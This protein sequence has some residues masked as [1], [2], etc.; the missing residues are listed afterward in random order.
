MRRA[1]TAVHF[2]MRSESWFQ[3]SL[4]NKFKF[5]LKSINNIEYYAKR[6]MSTCL[7]P[8][9]NSPS[10]H[11]REKNISNKFSRHSD[12]SDGLVSIPGKGKIFFSS[13]QR[14]DR[15]WGPPSL[16]SN[17]YRSLFRRSRMTGAWSS[18]EVKNGGAIPLLP[19]YVVMTW[20]LI[21]HKDKFSVS[22]KSC[23]EKWNT[24]SM[25]NKVFPLILQF[26]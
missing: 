9:C 20:R 7:N 15:L 26:F 8:E 11:Q 14:P 3:I 18:A 21:K 19:P 17:R 4:F 12:G 16:L 5:L 22:Y 25:L 13:P 23:T 24:Y 2:S 1:R 6:Y 10:V